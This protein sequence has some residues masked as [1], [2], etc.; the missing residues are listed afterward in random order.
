MLF[1]SLP[2]RLVNIKIGLVAVVFVGDLLTL[3]CW[4]IEEL[5]ELAELVEPVG[6]GSILISTSTFIWISSIGTSSDFLLT[7]SDFLL[8]SSDFLLTSSDFLLT[9]SLSFVLSSL[10]LLLFALKSWLS[11][12]FSSES[13]KVSL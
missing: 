10:G 1:F 13:C 4:S 2:F 11:S 9:S 12:I 5:V 3:L 8:A 6:M 7:S